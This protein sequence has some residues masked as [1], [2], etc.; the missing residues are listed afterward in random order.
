MANHFRPDNSSYHVVDYNPIDGSVIS[1]TTSQGLSDSSDWARGQAWGLYGYTM[2]YRETGDT[3]FLNMA[4]KIADFYITHP[5]M[6]PDLVPFWDFDAFDYRDASAACIVS[7]ALMELSQYASD[8]RTA[9]YNFGI[10]ILKTISSSTYSAV[11]GTNNDFILKHSVGNKPKSI[12]VDKPLNYADHFFIEA[13]LRYK[14]LASTP[15]NYNPE[16]TIISP[17]A[18]ATY[19]AGDVVTFSGSGKDIEGGTLGTSAF[20]WY[21]IFHH[22]A[23]THPGPYAPSGVAGGSFSIPNIGETSPNVFYRLYL[24]VTDSRGAKDTAYTDI[25]PRTSTITLNTN[26][27]GLKLSLDGQPII[28]PFTVTSVE[29]MLRTLDVISPQTINNVYTFNYNNWSQGGYK[30]QTITTPASNVTYKAN[31]YYL[32][33]NFQDSSTIPPKGWLRDFGQPFASRI[34][35]YQGTGHMYGWIIRSDKKPL[36]LTLNGRKRTIPSNILLATLMHMQG[37]DII[38]PTLIPIE[39]IWEVKVPNGKYTA[40]VSVGDGIYLNSKHTINVEGINAINS[41]IPSAE[42]MFKSAPVKVLVTDNFLSIDAIGG[43]NTK[44]NSVIIQPA[45]SIVRLEA[46]A[47]AFVRAGSYA[48]NNYGS[49]ITLM[50]KNSSA[51]FTRKSYLKFTLNNIINISSAMLRI[52]GSNWDDTSGIK[53]SV[54]GIDNDVWTEYGITW[55]NAPVAL[56]TPTGSAYVNDIPQYHE[57]DVTNFVKTQIAG[58][59]VVSL[60]INDGSN[61]KLIF[62]SKEGGQNVPELILIT[63]TPDI[64]SSGIRQFSEITQDDVNS[65]VRLTLSPNPARNILQLYIIGLQMFKPSTILVIS[66][67]GVILKTIKS[68]TT[69]KIV[70]LNLSSLVSGVFTIKVISGDKI[71]YKQFVKL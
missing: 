60:L 10:D 3:R 58:D 28:T 67:S 46:V 33:I 37:N 2:C 1:K 39:G 48:N 59:K 29:G 4:K 65:A 24:V 21:V 26:P 27:Q 55:N 7:S 22:N 34:S 47:D 62:N 52:Y 16:A 64:T 36:D 43:F 6:P 17:G 68:N 57:I 45:V 66:S 23:H 13:L 63:E 69:P 9:Y 15:F 25:L 35:S 49:S 19:A 41:F 56:I 53:V 14:K 40:T 11:V 8:K 42:T 18:G 70:Q 20:E 5:N 31:F 12:E 51:D 38:S 54:Y 44:L 30:T 61:N 50:L 71:M 32:K